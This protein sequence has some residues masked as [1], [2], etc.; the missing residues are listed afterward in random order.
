MRAKH[1]RQEEQQVQRSRVILTREEV[2]LES[3]RN[4]LSVHVHIV[5]LSN[6]QSLFGIFQFQVGNRINGKTIQVNATIPNQ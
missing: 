6:L 2:I 3:G 5:K 4:Y 1:Y